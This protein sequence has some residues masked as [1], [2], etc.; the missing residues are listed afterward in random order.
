MACLLR[1]TW[2]MP[3]LRRPPTVQ[4]RKLTRSTTWYAWYLQWKN[5]W[6]CHDT[7]IQ[8]GGSF[9]SSGGR[10][11]TINTTR[12]TAE[13]AAV[14]MARG[15][16]WQARDAS[17]Q[18]AEVDRR[19]SVNTAP[20][21]VLAPSPSLWASARRSSSNSTDMDTREWRSAERILA[22]VCKTLP[23]DS[24]HTLLTP[25]RPHWSNSGRTPDG[26]LRRRRAPRQLP[27]ST[28]R[29]DAP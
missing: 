15:W 24:I 29:M 17:R 22:I 16:K 14:E 9:A 27:G 20:A 25:S 8:R 13:R 3:K 26:L 2:E 4:R 11:G 7:H 28:T 18:K 5:T 12:D 21:P 6:L 19:K 1:L 10:A 23:C